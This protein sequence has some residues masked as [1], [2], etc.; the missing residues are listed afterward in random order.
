MQKENFSKH[1]IF[2]ER[3]SF[4]TP[5]RTNRK[6]GDANCKYSRPVLAFSFRLLSRLSIMCAT[7][8]GPSTHA[9]SFFAAVIFISL[10]FS[11]TAH[12]YTGVLHAIKISPAAH[13][14][15]RGWCAKLLGFVYVYA[16]VCK[17]ERARQG[18]MFGLVGVSLFFY[19][20]VYIN[21]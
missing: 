21:C 18:L 2:L 15:R 1:G 6:G 4:I 5:D 8:L 11:G 16:C 20:N 9:E 19:P 17:R 13:S 7:S 10:I 14:M 12:T 3:P